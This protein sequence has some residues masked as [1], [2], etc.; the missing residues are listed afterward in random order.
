[1]C[2]GLALENCNSTQKLRFLVAYWQI[3][4]WSQ[5]TCLG[6]GLA[7]Y[8]VMRPSS[9]SVREQ[10]TLNISIASGATSPE[11]GMRR[12]GP[13]TDI[14]KCSS[15]IRTAS[16][17]PFQRRSGSIHARTSSVGIKCVYAAV[18]ASF[19]E[20]SH[21]RE[22][23][24]YYNLYQHKIRSTVVDTYLLCDLRF[25]SDRLISSKIFPHRPTKPAKF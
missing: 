4:A 2:P 5:E 9:I 22:I 8:A 6:P 21:I 20:D 15:V 23:L 3:F 17:K 24:P 19:Q 1:M 13:R 10:D 18:L 25:L 14:E 12:I 11:Y 7:A 16:V